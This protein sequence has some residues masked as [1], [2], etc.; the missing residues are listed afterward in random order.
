MGWMDEQTPIDLSGATFPKFSSCKSKTPERFWFIKDQFVK[1]SQNLLN[2]GNVFTHIGARYWNRRWVCDRQPI[3]KSD[4]ALFVWELRL[5]YMKTEF[6]SI[7]SFCSYM[8]KHI[9][10][11]HV[12]RFFKHMRES[13]EGYL[14]QDVTL[15]GNEYKGPIKTNKQ[16]IDA[17]LYSDNFHTQE[18]YKKRFDDLLVYIDES[19]ILKSTYN[20]MHCGYQLNQITRAIK[21]LKESHLVVLLPNHLQHEWNE[22]CPYELAR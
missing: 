4:I 3:S 2:E 12:V 9:K 15:F 18:K 11:H 8:E 5:F 20:A 17:L 19:L 14:S 16:L 6:M 10:N 13:W 21:G 22:D 7:Y 1:H